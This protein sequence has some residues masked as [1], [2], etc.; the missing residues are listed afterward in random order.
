MAVQ[1]R[2]RFKDVLEKLDKLKIL[3][4]GAPIDLAAVAKL[5]NLYELHLH[6][7]HSDETDLTPLSGLANLQNVCIGMRTQRKIV[8]SQNLKADP[9]RI[10]SHGVRSS[11]RRIKWC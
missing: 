2:R 1:Q 11:S 5:P 8:L 10:L 3:I 9:D 7:D 6:Y 4:L